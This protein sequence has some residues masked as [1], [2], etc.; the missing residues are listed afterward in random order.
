MGL[1][2][3]KMKS[4]VFKIQG[5]DCA[6][7]IAL[8]KKGLT[9]LVAREENLGFD[10]LN[11]R[12]T[13]LVEDGSIS[14]GEII[15]VVGKLG[16]SAEIWGT[17]P[18]QATFLEKNKRYILTL[19]SFL[20]L[21]SGFVFH[22]FYH[23]SIQHAFLGGDPGNEPGFPRTT[24]VFYFLSAITGGW[25]V[26]PRALSA[27]RRLQPDMNLLMTVAVIGAM[28][29]GEWFEAAT[30]A[31]LFSLS[32][33]LES[34]SVDRARRATQA[35]LALTP[36]TARMVSENG[37]ENVIA[38]T[39]VK[40]GDIFLVR[41]GERFPLDGT[42]IKGASE[43]NQASITGESLPVTKS[44]DDKIFAGSINGNG[45]LE[46][47]CDKGFEQSTISN[48]IKMVGEAHLR[49]APS[50]QWVES[51]ARIYTPAVMIAALLILI[52][53]PLFFSGSWNYWIYNS[54]VLL[55][56]ACPCALVISTPV[57]VV[58]ALAAAAKNGVL[59]KGGKYVEIPAKL[60]AIAFDKT[61]TITKGQLSISKI[62]PLNDHSE[63]DL[64]RIAASIESRS[65]HP[66]ARTIVEYANLKKL[67]FSPA[68]DY[69]TVQGKGATAK[70]G[71]ENFWL[72]SHR[73]LEEMH[74]ESPQV[75]QELEEL[76]ST[77][78]TVVALGDSKHVC[79]FLALSDTVRPDA[80]DIIRN[81]EQLGIK[82]IVMLTGDN[83]GTAR[84]VSEA[85]GIKHVYSELLPQDKV[86]KIEELV[87]QYATVA[88]VGDGIND[89]P[90][91]ARSTLGIAMGAAGS[92]AAIETADIA[93]M[94]DEISKI[95]WLISHSRRSLRI[96][97]Q[98]I[99]FSLAVKAVFMV[100]TMLGHASLWAAI[101][102]DMGASLL[103]I[104]NGLRL[105]R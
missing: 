7:E 77:G 22:W 55:V 12:L 36:D 45:A 24:V 97:R 25:I 52:V 73:Y 14:E 75:H 101:S 10:L 43:V 38:A 94:S 23:G 78:F 17:T 5:M 15:T 100:M 74:Q 98:N 68:N 51:F 71:D 69:Q 46:V 29:I 3:E 13:V 103:V 39:D 42:I 89:A 82:N 35:L 90:A 64:L 91:M 54:L 80:S 49:K 27:I 84:K 9:P 70:I 33:L 8:L 59:I 72:G 67:K 58:A 87:R 21:L 50:E 32:L 86:T 65:E 26:F 1:S 20:F 79:G 102:A 40:V 30:V 41:P 16:M 63:E 104:F 11:S 93:L 6:E 66:I 95:P 44:I 19:L 56:I 83:K 31:F 99:F 18:K 53:P 105:L 76:T 28:F 57:S 48:I 2:Q 37:V 81:I 61:G 96:I 60:N 92:D 4:L 88:M 85:V 62:I 47:R 34:W